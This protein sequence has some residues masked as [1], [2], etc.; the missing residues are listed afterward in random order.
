MLKK[1]TAT[2]GLAAVA[3]IAPGAAVAS[4]YPVVWDG[5]GLTDPIQVEIPDEIP[6][7]VTLSVPGVSLPIQEEYLDVASAPISQNEI[8]VEAAMSKVG[9]PYVYG[10]S[11]PEAFD[12]SGLTQW[13]YAQAGKSIPRTSYDQLAGGQRVSGEW[14]PGD[15]I[16]FYGGGHVGIY[17]GDGNF[18]HSP[19][20]GQTV[21]VASLDS[22]PADYA[23]RY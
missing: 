18:V 13:S 23:V 8:A 2:V 7:E 12:C 22:M 11:G 6:Q 10:A 5:A 14:L 4:A 16:S 17:I 3:A 21:H 9:S 20:S 19:T 15:I 1:F